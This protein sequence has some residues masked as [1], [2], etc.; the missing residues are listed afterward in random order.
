VEDG[1]IMAPNCRRSIVLLFNNKGCVTHE[2]LKLLV[3][4]IDKTEVIVK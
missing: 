2:E 4:R 3:S 1:E